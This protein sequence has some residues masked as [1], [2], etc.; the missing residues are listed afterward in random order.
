MSEGQQVP[1]KPDQPKPVTQL[2][3]TGQ[4]NPHAVEQNIQARLKDL[5]NVNRI[6]TNAIALITDTDIKGGHAGAVTEMLGWLTG[7]SESLTGQIKTLEETLPKKEEKKPIVPKV[8]E[9]SKSMP[10]E[11]TKLV[12][13]VVKPVSGK[14][15]A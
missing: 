3:P 1:T 11:P 8:T 15:K 14:V 4:P 10:P 12:E 7:F 5:T 2:D 13:P 6:V 9:V